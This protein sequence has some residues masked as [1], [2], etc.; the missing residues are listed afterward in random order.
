MI[1]SGNYAG[2]YQVQIAIVPLDSN[3][4]PRTRR[5]QQ[6]GRAE[7]SRQ[8]GK[9]AQVGIVQPIEMAEANPRLRHFL[10]PMPVFPPALE[11]PAPWQE[12]QIDP[13]RRAWQCQYCPAHV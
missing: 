9:E 2:K 6:E 8:D 7:A 3:S 10:R 4:P 1:F 5:R 11:A 12:H 13:T